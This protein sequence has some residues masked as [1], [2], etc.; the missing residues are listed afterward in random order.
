MAL[1]ELIMDA[2]SANFKVSESVAPICRR[3]CPNQ[4]QLTSMLA[5]EI[6]NGVL[7]F[8]EK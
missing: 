8:G 1:V 2:V 3:H 4:M 5:V 7:C 6:H